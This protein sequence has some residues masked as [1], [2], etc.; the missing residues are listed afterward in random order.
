MSSK[1]IVLSDTHF[2]PFTEFATFDEHGRNE[3]EQGIFL[4]GF[5]QGYRGAPYGIY[6]WAD[7]VAYMGENDFAYVGARRYQS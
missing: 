1:I 2:H 5:N 7:I 3:R 6:T 4:E